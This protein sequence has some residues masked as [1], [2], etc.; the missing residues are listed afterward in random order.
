MSN[1]IAQKV[2]N[3]LAGNYDEATKKI[4]QDLQNRI[5][6]LENK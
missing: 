5:T 6:I 4:I 1:N 2:S 3:W